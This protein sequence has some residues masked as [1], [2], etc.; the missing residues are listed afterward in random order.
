M[1]PKFNLLSTAGVYVDSTVSSFAVKVNVSVANTSSLVVPGS[2]ATSNLTVN[3]NI[4]CLS[5]YTI[6]NLLSPSFS[7]DAVPLTYL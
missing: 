3:S 1:A 5:S 4:D 7:G 6:K 2:Y